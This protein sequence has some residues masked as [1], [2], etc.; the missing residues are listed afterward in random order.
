MILYAKRLNHG[1]SEIWIDDGPH[2][3]IATN[4]VNWQVRRHSSKEE[5]DAFYATLHSEMGK[6][7]EVV[8]GD[9]IVA[10]LGLKR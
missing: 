10:E 4:E 1:R 8:A 9:A 5:Y 6:V 7:A 2:R 3:D